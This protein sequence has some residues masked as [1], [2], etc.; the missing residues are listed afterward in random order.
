MFASLLG[1]RR[2][3]PLFIVQ[4]LSALND[5]FVKTALAMLVLYRLGGAGQGTYIALASAALVVP[6]F[7]L[8]ALG[9]ELADKFD[10]ALVCRRLKLA[11]IPVAALAGLGF[12]VHSPVILLLAILG[13]GVI[14]ALFGPIKYGILPDHLKTE[15]LASGNALVEGATFAAIL[16]GT[17]AGGEVATAS[18]A[19]WLFVPA[20]M[21]FA[22]ICVA[23]AYGIPSTGAGSAGIKIN[24]NPLTST[25]HLLGELRQDRPSWIGGLIVSWFW[26]VGVAV[27][28]LLPQMVKERINGA[29]EVLNL[30]L[31][32]FTVG[33]AAGS[34]AAARLSKFRPNLALVPLG[35]L[36]MAIFGLDLALS[37]SGAAPAAGA[38]QLTISGF[39]HSFAGWRLAVDLTGLAF[40]GGLYVVPSFA[41]VQA[42][43]AADHRARVVAGVNVLNAAFM[44]AATVALIVLPMLGVSMPS[45]LA[46]TALGN[47]VAMVLVLRAWGRQGVQDFAMLIFKWAYGLEITGLENLPPKGSRVVITPNHT[48][49]MDGPVMHALLPSHAS[50]AVDTG[51][52]EAW[53]VKPFLKLINAHTM[54]PTKPFATRDLI[55]IVKTG[56]TLVIFPEGRLTVTSGLMKVYEG[57]GLIADK[58]DAVVVPVRI[59]GLE[60]TPFSYLRVTQLAKM[61]FP[62][63]RV[64]ILPPRKLTIDPALNG[65]DRRRAAGAALNDIMVE[66]AVANARIDRTLFQALA[67][68]KFE[69]DVGAIMIEDP[70]R[71]RLTYSK[72]ITGAQVLGAKIAPFAP[73]GAAVGIL[74][75]NTAGVVVAFYALQTIGR[76]AAMLN[77]TA[78]LAN[79]EAACMT[80]KVGVVL[81]S[82]NFIEKGRLSDMIQRLEAAGVHVVYLEDV[83]TTITW[84]DK[85]SGLRLGDRPQV[86]RDA[87]TPAAILFTSGSE[88]TPKGV[89]LSHRNILANVA[90]SLTTVP[91]NAEDK[92]FNALPVF[93]SFGLTAGLI[94]PL[95]SGTPI[96][97]YP[98]PLHYRIV[99]E[100]IY[101]YNATIVFSTDTFLNGYARSAHPYDF[102]SVRLILAGA[103]AVKQRTR[104]V[105]MERF[106]QRIL[107]GYGVT[108][109]SPVLAINT[110]VANKTGSVGRL[111]P[112]MQMRLDP[113]PGIEDG[114]RLFVR[115]PNV[116]LGYMKSDNPGVI[117]PPENGWHDTGDIVSVDKAGFITIKGR[118]K[119]FA[120]IGGE[121]ISLSAVEALAAE[122]WPAVVPVVVAV[123]DARK[124]ERLVLVTTDKSAA[125]EQILRA[126]KAK[127]MTE[128]SVPAEICVVER[129]PLLGS[130][131]TD[132]VA[133]A[134]LVKE[135]MAGQAGRASGVAA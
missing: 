2:F 55:N 61:R 8:S 23:A 106:G 122:V 108:E 102:R 99:P 126:A 95:T 103:E 92:V 112:L 73:E 75:P 88:G 47:L 4:F 119:R 63:V 69:R 27:M 66:S 33:I 59:E 124:G 85:L 36:L 34:I 52:A 111:S 40:A 42:G 118:A 130:G 19:D 15:E 14:A 62:K 54:D 24:R 133:V 77:Y 83:R 131:K 31:A 70:L 76:V 115:G 51:I 20:V 100:L 87:N 28:T 58:A 48:S 53:W 68:A 41:S 96:Y 86:S 32:L 109:T 93:H 104:D 71:T 37:L 26:L 46:L 43:A 1:S 105:Y 10:K 60:R 121:M 90:Q 80:A 65:R 5:N 82:R 129:L 116:M 56:E 97:L 128:L 72:L 29:P 89:V 120:K 134:G 67:T 127:G 25:F 78:G 21:V 17:V 113:V 114:G 6:F 91:A 64:T 117:Q 84:K 132:Y 12:V 98:S 39:F 135:R 11:E 49:F 57:A 94:M 13:Y 9:G 74:L 81:T 123:P 3:L 35:A 101:Q 110:P 30:A 125:R 45:I 44:T 22:G 107:E 38:A 50:F 7:F 16:I 79:V 18:G